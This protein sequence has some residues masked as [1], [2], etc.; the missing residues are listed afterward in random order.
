M[1]DFTIDF[2]QNNKIWSNFSQEI[3]EFISECLEF[4]PNKRKSAEQL[5]RSNFISLLHRK[6]L[7]KHHFKE[8]ITSEEQ[9]NCFEPSLQLLI[10]SIINQKIAVNDVKLQALSAIKDS[11]TVHNKNQQ[12]LIE[13]TALT[14]SN[15]HQLLCKKTSF[16]KS[17]KLQFSE[18]NELI[19]N[20]LGEFETNRLLKEVPAYDEQQV[21]FKEVESGIKEVLHYDLEDCI[22]IGFQK[23]DF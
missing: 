18:V 6:V 14:S 8:R 21:S 20:Q 11:F 4:D 17:P 16:D 2:E 1:S 9:I 23:L 7:D 3:K 5:L 22:K 13:V 19:K 10:I 12:S 15:N